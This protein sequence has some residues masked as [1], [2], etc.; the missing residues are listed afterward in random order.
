MY[1]KWRSSDDQNWMKL[2]FEILSPLGHSIVLLSSRRVFIPTMI[3]EILVETLKCV[4]KYSVIFK[5]S[6][7]MIKYSVISSTLS[8]NRRFSHVTIA[9]K[10]YSHFSF[11]FLIRN[12]KNFFNSLVQKGLM[13]TFFLPQSHMHLHKDL[14]LIYV[15]NAVRVQSHPGLFILSSSLFHFH[16][17]FISHVYCHFHFFPPFNLQLSLLLSFPLKLQFLL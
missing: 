8:L 4:L 6:I 16:F 3:I 17:C 7:Q 9:T 14:V 15:S 12:W 2:Y 10:L 1:L 13:V 5:R 11:W